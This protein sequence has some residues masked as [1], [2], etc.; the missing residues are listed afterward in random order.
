MRPRSPDATCWRSCPTGGGKSAIYELAGLVREGPTIVV[1]PLIALEDD[2]LAHLRAAGLTA[3]VVNSQQSARAHADA[4]AAAGDP[5]AFV[6]VSPEQLSN[7][8]TRETLRR[9]RPGLFAVDEAHLTSGR[10]S[11]RPC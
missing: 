5:D 7:G 1:S 4:L 10:R 8:E 3:L 9:A 6:F 2:Q 11:P